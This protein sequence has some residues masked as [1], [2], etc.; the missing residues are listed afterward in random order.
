MRL[1]GFRSRLVTPH[2]HHDHGLEA[3]G[4]AQRA[5]EAA[6]IADAFDVEQ[7]AA[8]LRIVGEVVEDFAEVEIG[9]RA[10]GDHAGKAD[11]VG[12]RPV[13]HGGADCAGLRHQREIAAQGGALAEGG[14]Q[15]DRRPLDAETVGADE[16]DAVLLRC[17]D[18]GRFQRRAWFAHLAETGRQHDGVT[19]AA[20][21]ALCHDRRDGRRGGGDQRQFRHRR[22]LVGA[23]V[24]AFAEHRLVLGVD[25][26]DLAAVARFAQIAEQRA[27]NRVLALAGAEDR[28]RA[29][30]EQ[31]VKIM[32]GHDGARLDGCSL[33]DRIRKSLC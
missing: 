26:I 33:V 9:R 31:R 5:H 2:F 20:L 8:R 1:H 6:R 30:V 16:A 18:H 17:P 25:R 24:A 23:G 15:P 14:V 4:G 28:H 22:Q 11:A 32:S 3:G 10:G 7:N 27:G 12:F 13:Q 29:G 21:A 19:D